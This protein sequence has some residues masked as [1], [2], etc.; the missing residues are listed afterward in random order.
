[1]R[2]DPAD[3]DLFVRWRNEPHVAEWW[4]TDDDP[5]PTTFERVVE[6]YGPRAEPDADTTSCLIELGAHPIGYIQF[7]RWGSYADEVR[8]MG[9]EL[10]E[11]ASGIDVFV[12]EPDM[13]GEGLG[14]RAVDLLARF[15][16]WER[17]APQ[18]AIV[19]AVDNHRAQRAYEKAG[20][21]KIGVVLDTDV[22]GGERVRS[23]LM[24]RERPGLT[25]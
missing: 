19:T 4:T 21:R 24:T 10:R 18:V 11:G 13:V 8:A 7:Y 14:S 15:L 16:F 9:L 20:F 2:D 17:G 23:W 5:T 3:Y 22:R 25:S 6:K 12:G 1:M